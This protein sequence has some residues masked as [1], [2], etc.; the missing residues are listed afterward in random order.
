MG[1]YSWYGR[2]DQVPFLSRIYNLSSLPS[3]DSRFREAASDIVQHTLNNYDWEDTWIFYDERFGLARS[4]ESLLRFLAETV[5]PAIRSDRDEVTS[6]VTMYNSHLIHDGYELVKVREIS[7][8]PIFEGRLVLQMPAA[9]DHVSAVI[10]VVDRTYLDTQIKLMTDSIERDPHV[11]IGTAKE[12]V[13]TICKTI[14]DDLDVAPDSSWD[15]GRLVRETS[16]L[17]A[18]TPESISPNAPVAN[19]IKRLLGNLAQ[20]TTG[21]AELR[22]SYGTGHGRALGTAG[23]NARHARLAVGSASTLAFFLYETHE[24]RRVLSQDGSQRANP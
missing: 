2:L 20:V 24:A 19:T 11:A 13:E 14:L 3:T 23:L 5:H 6:L 18:L 12:M 7:G 15:L 4:D 9:L 22:N 1:G 21:L 10:R 8:R 16:S 17:L